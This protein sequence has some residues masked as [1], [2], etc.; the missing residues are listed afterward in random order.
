[1]GTLLPVLMNVIQKAAS[2]LSIIGYLAGGALCVL[3]K[4][5]VYVQ[6]RVIIHNNS[7]GQRCKEKQKSCD[8][9]KGFLR[10]LQWQKALRSYDQGRFMAAEIRAGQG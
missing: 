8:Q 9:G 7:R 2:L 1:M 5:W 6:P 3:E 4:L 10:I